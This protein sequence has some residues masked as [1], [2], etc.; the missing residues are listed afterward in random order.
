MSGELLPSDQI[1]DDLDRVQL[2]SRSVRGV[3][4]IFGAQIVRFSFNFLFQVWLAHHLTPDDFGVVAMATP[5]LV[6]VGL[7]SDLGL[8]QATIQRPGMTDAQL[9]FIFWANAA[10]GALL[11]AALALCS[12]LIAGFYREPRV[13]GAIMVL[14][15]GLFVGCT[16]SQHLALLTRRL[17]FGKL[18]IIDLSS[19][20]AG[21]I[22]AIAAALGGA[23]YWSLLVNQVG[24]ST[25]AMLLTFA[26]VR[27]RPRRPAGAPEWREM[28]MLGRDLTLGNLADLV[29]TNLDNVLIGRFSGSIALGFYDRAYKLLLL[30]VTQITAPVS[31]VAL[32]LLAR[33]LNERELYRRAYR[34]LTEVVALLIIPPVLTAAVMAD[35]VVSLLLGPT[36]GPVG[37]IFRLLGL[38]ALATP[39]GA[40]LSWLLTS[41]GRA[42]EIRNWA[43]LRAAL[44]AAGFAIGVR[45][46]V[47]GVS[48]SVVV[49]A[50]LLTPLQL[51]VVSRRGPVDQ[52]T[53]RSVTYPPVVGLCVCAVSL[54]TLRLLVSSPIVLLGLAVVLAYPIYIGA[55]AAT[56]GGREALLDIAK[57]VRTAADQRVGKAAAG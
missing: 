6:F 33:T 26:L 18:A 7:F 36:W 38:S 3:G 9:S 8:T 5:L 34:R 42:R 30:P 10:C 32:P 12:P 49:V 43:F 55:L 16:Y 31:R 27:W 51:A 19:T 50:F 53:V 15:L 1:A 24:S 22:M 2:K 44:M 48:A 4:I 25:T 21:W 46:G 29:S 14:A 40:G 39:F 41:Q 13:G 17:E 54:M 37:P 11:A 45:W 47:V 56:R 52:N 23:G 57:Q 28:L 35:L 20:A